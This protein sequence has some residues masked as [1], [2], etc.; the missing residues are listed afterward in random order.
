MYL[1]ALHSETVGVAR[2]RSFKCD[3]NINV[4]EKK[5]R[6]GAAKCETTLSN[7]FYCIVTMQN[8]AFVPIIDLL[9]VQGVRH[10]PDFQKWLITGDPT[11]LESLKKC[12]LLFCWNNR[13]YVH[14]SSPGSNALFK[15][16][17]TASPLL[18]DTLSCQGKAKKTQNN[19][20]ITKRE[21]KRGISQAK[22]NLTVGQLWPAGATLGSPRT[23]GI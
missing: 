20:Y 18:P 17:T 21:K 19:L 16:Y 14:R 13:Q 4:H 11:Y 9:P 12:L 22:L 1:T 3:K 15:S 7:L 5:T 23:R 6:G 2:K 10:C 8:D